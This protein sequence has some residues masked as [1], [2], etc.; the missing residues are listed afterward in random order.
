MFRGVNKPI[1]KPMKG[2]QI[3]LYGLSTLYEQL[4][5]LDKL[6]HPKWKKDLPRRVKLHTKL[7]VQ[8]VMQ[9]KGTDKPP[10]RVKL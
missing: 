8:Q 10:S 7:F 1:S 6:K 4:R 3:K 5:D 2:K 9:L